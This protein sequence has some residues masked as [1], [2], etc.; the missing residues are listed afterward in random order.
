MGE[1]QGW[2]QQERRVGRGGVE[3]LTP[4][5][6]TALPGGRE[7]QAGS[8]QGVS[9]SPLPAPDPNTPTCQGTDAGGREGSPLRVLERNVTLMS[10][11]RSGGR[12]HGVKP[13]LSSRDSS[14]SQGLW[15]RKCLPK[16]RKGDSIVKM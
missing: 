13:K 11:G 9:R 15:G 7:G 3:E 16:W 5:R 10:E 8:L 12:A 14:S 2:G 6:G 1:G 4:F